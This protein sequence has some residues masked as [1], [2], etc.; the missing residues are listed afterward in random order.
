MNVVIWWKKYIIHPYLLLEA[1][2]LIRHSTS[3]R[4]SGLISGSWFTTWSPVRRF[5]GESG[6]GWGLCGLL[7][8]IPDWKRKQNKNSWNPNVKLIS[9]K[10]AQKA[11]YKQTWIPVE[12]CC[13]ICSELSQPSTGVV[14]ALVAEGSSSLF[15]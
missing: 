15:F 2:A 1:W 12:I 8:D 11:E 13:W 10:K 6:G 7:A 9:R 3:C 5:L 4:R 14:D